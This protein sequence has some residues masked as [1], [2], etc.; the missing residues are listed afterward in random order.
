MEIAR[1]KKEIMINQSG[2]SL[3]RNRKEYNAEWELSLQTSSMKNILLRQ[4]QHVILGEIE[5]FN[6]IIPIGAICGGAPGRHGEP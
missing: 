4:V 2:R 5:T 6:D 1:K 3:G